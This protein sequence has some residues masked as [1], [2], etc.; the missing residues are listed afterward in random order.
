M[1]YLWRM[2]MPTWT[3]DIG[4]AAH[5]YRALSGHVNPRTGNPTATLGQAMGRWVGVN[6]YP[7]EPEY[8]RARNRARNI[9]QFKFELNDIKSRLRIRVRDQNLDADDRAKLVA[10]YSKLIRDKAEEMREY[11]EKSR[12]HPNLRVK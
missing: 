8:T 10:T 5:T 11:A 7:I 3:T 6:V 12:V 9:Q 4:A 1:T 2:A